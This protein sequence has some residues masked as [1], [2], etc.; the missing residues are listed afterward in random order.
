MKFLG[1]QVLMWV[2]TIP[3][4]EYHLFLTKSPGDP[5]LPGFRF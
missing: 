4:P 1:R 2:F 5:V 3:L